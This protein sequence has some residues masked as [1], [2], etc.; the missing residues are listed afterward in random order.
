MVLN[1]NLIKLLMNNPE[2]SFALPP[3]LIYS[4]DTHRN[5]PWNDTEYQPPRVYEDPIKQIA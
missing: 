3:N 2:R 4:Y 1:Y 5:I